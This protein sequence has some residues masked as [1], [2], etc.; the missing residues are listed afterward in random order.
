[1]TYL[2]GLVVWLA[3]IAVETVHGTLRGLFIQPVLGDLP[4]RQLGVPVACLLNFA[5]TWLFIGWVKPTARQALA[6]G[7]A[8][9]VLTVIFELGLGLALGYSWARL[10][11]DYNVAEGGF[12]PL[13]LAVLALSPWLALKLRPAAA[14]VQP[15]AAS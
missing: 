8:W 1:M 7:A 13:G 3:I 6:I 12:M 10:M 11:Q 15:P 9:V 2:R 4:A 14:K 5:T